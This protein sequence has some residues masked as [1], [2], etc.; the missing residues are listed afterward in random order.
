MRRALL[1]LTLCS[2]LHG[3][4]LEKIFEEDNL[5]PMR[6][7]L[8]AGRYDDVALICERAIQQGFKLSDWRLMRIHVLI[9]LGREIEARDEVQL[10]V[11][12]FPGHLEL[13]MLQHDNARRIGRKDITARKLLL[14]G[15]VRVGPECGAGTGCEG[16][17]RG[18][19]LSLPLNQLE[20]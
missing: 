19:S 17:W 6:R 4:D 1:L 2:A 9:N 10:A 7:V 8:A 16:V 20:G 11:K 5:E 15:P 13:L 12:T 14:K 3:Q 18:C